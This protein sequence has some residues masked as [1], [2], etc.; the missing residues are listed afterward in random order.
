MLQNRRFSAWAS[1]SGFGAAICVAVVRNYYVLQLSLSRPQRNGC[2]KVPR[3]C[4]CVRNT[5]AFC[6]W[7]SSI[8][9]L[10]ESCEWCFGS[11]FFI[12][13]W[14]QQGKTSSWLIIAVNCNDL[15]LFPC[16]MAYW[17]H[18]SPTSGWCGF[19]CISCLRLQAVWRCYC[20]SVAF[21]VVKQCLHSWVT[22]AP[23][24]GQACRYVQPQR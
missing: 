21:N 23:V 5:V 1:R 24:H 6:S 4:G 7:E 20:R 18:A 11:T 2:A 9:L 14:Y 19:A 10:S 15:F 3:C 12:T 13:S 22:S 8:A 17:P 16:S